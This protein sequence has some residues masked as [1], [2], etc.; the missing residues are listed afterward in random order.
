MKK[1]N[2]KSTRLK[3]HDYSQ[4]GAYF[5]TICAHKYQHLFGDIKNNQIR[6]NKFGKIVCNEWI[7]TPMIRRNI[8]LDS[9]V[10]MP[11]HFHGVIHILQRRGTA[12]RAPT[13][14]RFGKP[15]CGSVPTIVRSF[16]SAVTKRINETRNTSRIP[17]WQRNYFEHI[18]RNGNDLLRIQKYVDNNPSNWD[19]DRN[20]PKNL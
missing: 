20:N 13:M 1:Y 6:L 3:N 19:N 16:K 2:R 4:N 11:N 14:E 12:R 8:K 15:V 5:V 18:I 9:F 17:I 7:K 10:V